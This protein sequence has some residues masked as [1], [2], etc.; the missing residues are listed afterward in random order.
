MTAKRQEGNKRSLGEKKKTKVF[1]MGVDV[2]VVVAVG[3][4]LAQR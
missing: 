2:R 4:Q 1:V 3:V